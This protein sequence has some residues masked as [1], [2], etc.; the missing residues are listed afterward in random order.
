[1]LLSKVGVCRLF[2][3]WTSGDLVILIFSEFLK[4][5]K[6][7]IDTCWPKGR[8]S[9][10]NVYIVF[11]HL[12]LRRP[13]ARAPGPRRLRE[14]LGE[15]LGGAHLLPGLGAPVGKQ[16]REPRAEV[17]A[18]PTRDLRRR[19]LRGPRGEPGCGLSGSKTGGGVR[20]RYIPKRFF[21][22]RDFFCLELN[23]RE[24]CKFL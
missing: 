14:R 12:V 7:K 22:R 4:K 23:C 18:G 24:F 5:K 19:P 11:Q 16:R 3:F 15:R 10:C 20:G 1:M 8:G 6:K 13:Q 17:A 21:F 2:S 9:A